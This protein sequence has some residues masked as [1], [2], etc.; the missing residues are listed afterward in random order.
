MTAGSLEQIAD[1]LRAANID[2][3]KE[4]ARAS[5]FQH[6]APWSLMQPPISLPYALAVAVSTAQRVHPST[7]GTST[8]GVGGVLSFQVHME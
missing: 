6:L 5:P 1:A 3:D 2:C 8:R 7:A 4:D